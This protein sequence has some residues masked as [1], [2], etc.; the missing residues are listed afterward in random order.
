MQQLGTEDKVIKS[1]YTVGKKRGI[2]LTESRSRRCNNRGCVGLCL[3]EHL[4][5]VEE[6]VVGEHMG[7]VQVVGVVGHQLKAVVVAC[8]QVQEEVQIVR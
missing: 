5:E 3:A 6:H 4:C 2:I 1:S 7:E 8:D